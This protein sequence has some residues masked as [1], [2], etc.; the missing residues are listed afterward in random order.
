LLTI[1]GTGGKNS[2]RLSLKEITRGI[3]TIDADII[4][5]AAAYFLV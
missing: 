2:N 1:I 3:D 5:C 4:E